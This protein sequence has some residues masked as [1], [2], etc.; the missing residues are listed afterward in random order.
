MRSPG[1]LQGERNSGLKPPLEG[2]SGC[3]ATKADGGHSCPKLR[4]RLRIGT[5]LKM[6]LAARGCQ[7]WIASTA[8]VRAARRATL[9]ASKS[10][11]D[12]ATRNGLREEQVTTVGSTGRCLSSVGMIHQR[13]LAGPPA[14]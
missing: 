9:I 1:P 3:T 7:Q 14:T 8:N 5:V 12:G 10:G 13:S 11:T 6:H 2:P 4:R